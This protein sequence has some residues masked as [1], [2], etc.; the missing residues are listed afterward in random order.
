MAVIVASDGTFARWHGYGKDLLLFDYSLS[1]STS[2]GGAVVNV[3]EEVS[4]LSL[5]VNIE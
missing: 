4:V 1:A 3:V 5:I 2:D